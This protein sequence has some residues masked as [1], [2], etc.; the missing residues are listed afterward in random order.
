MET[1]PA[2]VS[3]AAQPYMTRLNQ[4]I[5]RSIHGGPDLRRGIPDH[6]DLYPVAGWFRMSK[7]FQMAIMKRRAKL[8]HAYDKKTA[9]EAYEISEMPLLK[10]FKPDK[11]PVIKLPPAAKKIVITRKKRIKTE[12]TIPVINFHTKSLWGTEAQCFPYKAKYF[13]RWPVLSRSLEHGEVGT[14]VYCSTNRKWHF[15]AWPFY[16]NNDIQ[17]F[18][19][20]WCLKSVDARYADH[21]IRYKELKKLL[22][23]EVLDKRSFLGAYAPLPRSTHYY[24]SPHWRVWS[25]TPKASTSSLPASGEFSQWSKPIVIPTQSTQGENP[26]DKWNR[27]IY[28]L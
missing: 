14:F 1:D 10:P 5:R 4:R 24:S 11:K 15:V 16:K 28:N 18:R 27:N 2:E 8:L 21:F 20:Q 9:A 7:P 25:G 6:S 3:A 22:H 17:F 12:S 19:C 23:K 13:P 26:F